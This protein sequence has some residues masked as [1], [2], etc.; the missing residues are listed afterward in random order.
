ME[1]EQSPSISYPYAYGYLDSI[2][3]DLAD[4]VRIKASCEN[5]E[6]SKQVLDIIQ[7]RVDHI[8][9]QAY[10]RAIIE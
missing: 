4:Y 10:E 8:R 5:I 3:N 7:E 2:V 9:T 6:I 1:T